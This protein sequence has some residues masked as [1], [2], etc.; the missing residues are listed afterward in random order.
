MILKFKKYTNLFIL[1]LFFLLVI[2]VYRKS[3]FNTLLVTG[4]GI[5]YF[6]SKHFLVDSLSSGELPLWNPYVALGSPFLADIQQTVFSPFNLIY[7]FFDPVTGFNVFHLLQLSLGGFFMYLYINELFKVRYISIAVGLVFAFSSMIGGNRIEHTTIITTIVFSP[8]ILY[9][10]ERLKSTG[11]DKYLVF[12]SIGMAIHFLSGFTQIVI[13]FDIF[14]FFYFL[15][16]HKKLSYSWITVVKKLFKWIMPFLLLCAIQIIPTLQLMI[17]SGRNEVS[18]DFFSV[19][20]YDLRILLM[21]IFPYIFL[22]K[23]S[24]FGDYASSGIDIEIYL[25]IIPL[26][27]ILYSILFYHRQKFVRFIT[28]AMTLSFLY[29]MAPNIPFVGKIIH[30]IPV[31]GSFRVSSRSLSIFLICGFILFGFTLSKLNNKQDIRRLMKLSCLSGAFIIFNLFMICSIFSQPSIPLEMSE[32]YSWD[33]KVFLPVVSLCVINILFLFLLY[34]AKENKYIKPLIIGLISVITIMDVGKYSIVKTATSSKVVLNDNI[35]NEVNHLIKENNSNYRSFALLDLPEQYYDD[36][37]KTAKFQRSMLSK[38]SFYNSYSTFIDKK[39]QNYNISETG[40]YSNT[41]N[42]FN[43][44]NDLISMM[45]IR[46]ILDEWNHNFNTQVAT[47]E[48]VKQVFRENDVQIPFNNSQLSVI[49]YPIIIEANSSYQI[50]VNM[51]VSDTPQLF[52]MDLYNDNYDDTRQDARFNNIVPGTFEYETVIQTDDVI[53]NDQVNFRIV[54]QA[55]SDIFI[56]KVT[57]DKVKTVDAY[58]NVLKDGNLEVYENIN[59][60]PILYKPIYV[61]SVYSFDNSLYKRNYKE[62]L[63]E[64]NYIQN[65]NRDINLSDV[66]TNIYDIIQKNNSVSAMID[67]D[68]DT[69]INH[70]QLSYPGWKVFVDGKHVPIYN[71][72]NLIQGAEVPKGIHKIVFKYDPIDIKIGAFISFIGVLIC[73]YNI[74]NQFFKKAFKN[75]K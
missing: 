17:Q 15:Y 26:I 4:D 69:F 75:L 32:Y 44:R 40:Y 67:T 13:Y 41:I 47:D 62:R 6:I 2:V 66:K 8:L 22:N 53:P 55:N 7:L 36:K 63:D 70:S 71:V 5:T 16:V 74:F 33:G 10:L 51:K 31:L 12:S 25:G 58:K 50:T 57:V 21:M 39:Y 19:L 52:Y 3:I 45:S 37:L 54:S 1:I 34:I 59:A 72:N 49:N 27:Y 28:G 24:P 20:S 42:S 64:T 35:T 60:K 48:I 30:N 9:F 18:Y 73:C 38:I 56:K 65:F 14:F 46:Y 11:K 68:R 61:K 43:T 23:F 29:G